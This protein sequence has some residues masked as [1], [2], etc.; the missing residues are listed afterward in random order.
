MSNIKPHFEGIELYLPSSTVRI[1]ENVSVVG[2]TAYEV[3]L[4]K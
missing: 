3:F 2:T 1:S 4:F